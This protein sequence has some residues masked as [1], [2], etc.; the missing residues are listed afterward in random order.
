MPRA[1]LAPVVLVAAA[2]L[3]AC[4]SDTTASPQAQAIFV[5]SKTV[6][7]VGDTMLVKAGLRYADGRFEEFPSYTVSITDTT[8]A[9]VQAGTKIV[10]AKSP[11]NATVRVRIPNQTNFQLDS[12]YRI[13]GTR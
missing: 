10:Q 7:N 6:L 5:T 13:N 8:L 2:L 12:V 4:S 11:G 9:R 3:A 1:L